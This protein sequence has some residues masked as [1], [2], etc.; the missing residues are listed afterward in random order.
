MRASGSGLGESLNELG[1]KET[2]DN[3]R[4]MDKESEWTVQ[5]KGAGGYKKNLF[6]IITCMGIFL[7]IRVHTTIPTNR[8]T[9]RHDVSI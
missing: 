6:I 4:K 5:L 8:K 7:E 3:E 9:T 1:R 2:K